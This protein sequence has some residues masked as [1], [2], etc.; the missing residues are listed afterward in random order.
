MEFSPN[1]YFVKEK[2]PTK[3]PDQST[4]FT[5]HHIQTCATFNLNFLSFYLIFSLFLLLF[6]PSFTLF[7]TP[8]PP[9]KPNLP[10]FSPPTPPPKSNLQASKPNPPTSN[11]FFTM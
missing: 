8:F 3:L 11:H 7:T 9:T 1:I 4:P 6:P 5:S 2:P 10:C